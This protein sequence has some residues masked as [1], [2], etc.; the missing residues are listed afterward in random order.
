M[1]VGDKYNPEI[2]ENVVDER[3]DLDFIIEYFI[4]T[5]KKCY[6]YRNP[7]YHLYNVDL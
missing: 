6:K 3:I 7:H 4:Y 1:I 5:D 2:L